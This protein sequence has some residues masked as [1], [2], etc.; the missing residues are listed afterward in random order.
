MWF[1][2]HET[3]TGILNDLD[4]LAQMCRA[5]S[6]RL[7]VDAVSAV[8]AMPVD[9]SA[10][11]LASAVSGKALGAF[12]GLA[13]VLH[14]HSIDASSQRLPRYLDLGAYANSTGVPY[15]SSSNQLRA[16]KAALQQRSD[17]PKHFRL[18]A[19]RTRWLRTELRRLG[20]EVVAPD[21]AAA[22]GIVT[23][24]LPA[25]VNSVRLGVALKQAGYEIATNSVY[26]TRRNWIQISTMW[27]RRRYRS[28]V[29]S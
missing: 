2:Q 6:V 20:L 12:P 3:S 1:V 24:T 19:R 16:L 26:L 27:R 22:A 17:W 14:N 21:A 29:R 28:C 4:A 9:L 25:E 13:I 11:Y 10:A 18:I 7:C 23:V 8:G 5:R 15:S